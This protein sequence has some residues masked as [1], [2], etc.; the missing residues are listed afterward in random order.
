MKITWL[1]LSSVRRYDNN[2]RDN[3]RAV[4]KVA[5][6]IREFG[7]QQPIVVDSD[8]VIIAGDTRYQAAVL[9]GLEKVPVL[10]A[11]SLSPEKARA[12]R[13]ADNK[14]GDLATW[15]DMKLAE[16]LKGIMGSLGDIGLTGFAT[17][18]FEALSMR[19]EAELVSLNTASE[20]APAAAAAPATED[21]PDGPDEVPDDSGEDGHVDDDQEEAPPAAMVPFTVLMAVDDRGAVFDA[22]NAAK[23][24]HS[25][26]T[27]AA[28]LAVICREYV[29][30][31]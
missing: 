13:L 9:L 19:M 6:S 8:R 26:E 29:I 2:P 18:E 15:D 10:V 27:S 16:E 20:A 21:D 11:S 25:I 3:A 30:N 14:T 5:D 31:A 24:K 12:Y 1:S 7:W 28:A 4:Q 23:A 22:I 17:G